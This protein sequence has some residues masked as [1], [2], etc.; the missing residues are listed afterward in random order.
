[1]KTATMCTV[2]LEVTDKWSDPVSVPITVTVKERQRAGIRQRRRQ[3]EDR[4]KI[5]GL[6]KVARGNLI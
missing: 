3:G 2:N 5:S 6:F 1:M 4:S